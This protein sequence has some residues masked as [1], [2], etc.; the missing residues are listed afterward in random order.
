MSLNAVRLLHSLCFLL[1]VFTTT[2]TAD[3]VDDLAAKSLANV[4]KILA[5]SLSD[6]VS[7]HCTKDKLIVRRE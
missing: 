4:G 1:A 2:V 7:S 6:G 3:A 5:G